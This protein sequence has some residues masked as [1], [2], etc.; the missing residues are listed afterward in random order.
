MIQYIEMFFIFSRSRKCDII[1][2]SSDYDVECKLLLEGD[3]VK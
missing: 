1:V 3:K 2:N